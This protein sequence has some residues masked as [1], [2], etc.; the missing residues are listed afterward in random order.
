MFSPEVETA[1]QR[2][3]Q[4]A[5]TRK[6]RFADL[7]HLLLALLLD[8]QT[9]KLLIS[10]KVN[11][12]TIKSDTEALV[13][14]PD[15][16]AL[17][18][19]N[20]DSAPTTALQRVIQRA[21]IN[22][23]T[24]GGNTMHGSHLLIS[25]MSERDAAAT[26]LL[27]R[28]G[29]TRHDL[30]SRTHGL[31]APSADPKKT[32]QLVSAGGDAGDK[33]KDAK[34]RKALETYCI[35]LNARA[36][37]GK[38]DAVIGRSKEIAR[39]VKVLGRRTKNNP[40]LV[41]DPGVGKTAI[42]EGLALQ[43]VSGDAPDALAE[44][45]IF[46]LEMAALVAGTRYRGDFEERLQ[47]VI[48]GLREDP[49]V[50][51]FVDEIHTLI[52]AGATSG[53]TLDAGN[54]LKPPL[55]RGEIR[56]IGATTYKEYRRHFEKD[57][58]LSRRFQKVDVCEF[59]REETL[60]MLE[61]GA[62]KSLRE[63]HEVEYDQDAVTTAVDLAIKYLHHRKLPDKAIDVLDEAASHVRFSNRSKKDIRVSKVDVEET[64]AGLANVPAEHMSATEK[65]RLQTLE[66]DMKAVIFDQDRA[67]DALASQVRLAKAGMREPQKPIGCYLF[68][69]PTGVGKTEVAR[70]LARSLGIELV[71]FDMSEYMERH[72]VSRLIGAPPGYVGF[73]QGGL[74]TD[75]VDQNP[76]CVLLLDEIE[77]AHPDLFNV[78]LQVMDHGKLTD[79][80]GKTVDFRNVILIM[81]S[82][83]GAAE[84]AK[85]SIGFA[86]SETAVDRSEDAVKS[87][88]KPEF[89][90]RLDAIIPFGAITLDSVE[91]IVDKFLSELEA[92]LTDRNVT[93]EITA[94]ARTWL[95]KQGNDS[96]MGARP[97][98]RV[99]QDKVKRP[100]AS[101]VLFGKLEQGG[102]AAIDIADGADELVMDFKPAVAPAE[103]NL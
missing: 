53:G 87:A 14:K 97:L 22:V 74:L 71:R 50:I 99:I 63:H 20:D 46:V 37:E 10:C 47:E 72:S 43:I 8:E 35:D 73:E 34:G 102:V 70:Q 19:E 86:R 24:G 2:A 89:R 12:E 79:N 31:Q 9:A 41:G 67:I 49:N 13:A 84:A 6:H 62:L 54:I 30:V 7:E 39:V 85:Q 90:N 42:A 52:G 25:M 28:C 15:R 51:L 82:N 93:V 77:K 33:S 44:K 38:I 3:L 65:E 23:Q 76:H 45:R 64:V 88:F 60:H 4:E 96:S 92:Q 21:A 58:A 83:V 101:E 81:T 36:A 18:K 5:T 80:N 40:L 98:A 66:R 68:S 91:L 59:D 17:L 48:K 32:G 95:A 61:Q 100:L 55:Q 27:T 78:L 16:E 29:V 75:K 1:L 56:C 26:T 94:R 57:E 11:I 69:G 103:A